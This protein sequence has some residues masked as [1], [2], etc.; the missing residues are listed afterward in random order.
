[1]TVFGVIY[2][3][4]AFGLA[5]RTELSRSEAQQMIDGLFASYPGLRSYFDETLA[6][7]RDW[8]YVQTLFG[9]RRVMA[10]LRASGPRRAAA[11]HQLRTDSKRYESMRKITRPED[12][13]V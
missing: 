13:I 1:M 4:S 7:G 3:I 5:Q 9:R 10:D 8:G 11:E 12:R 2:G 6:R